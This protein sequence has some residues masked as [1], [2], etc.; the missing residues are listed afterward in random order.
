MLRIF[1]TVNHSGCA[2][3]RA[4]LPAAKIAKLGLA[5]T[6]CFSNMDTG[7]E[8]LEAMFNW[9]NV[10]VGQ[11]AAG[12]LS[13]ALVLKYREMGKITSIDYDDLVYS[14]S[15]F[16]PAYR[17]LGTKEVKIKEL[18]GSESYMWKDGRDGFSLKDNLFRCYSQQDIL[19]ISDFITVTNETLKKVYADYI[20][21]QKEKIFIL[22]N[23]IDFDLF[24]PFPKK[25]HKEIRIGWTASSSHHT[26]S[27]L[28]YRIFKKLFERYPSGVKFVILG[29]VFNL[30]ELLGRT[31]VEYSP[32]IGL[33]AYP[34]KFASMQF[35]IGICPL[36]NDEFN[37][38]KSQLKWSEFSALKIPSVV[39]NL[40]PY[41]VVEEGVTGYKAKTEDEF[42]EK[43]SLLIESEKLRQ[44]IGNN[45]F[46][47]NYQDFNLEKN[48]HL[49]VDVYSG[50][51]KLCV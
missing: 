30:D 8:D 40:A 28:V 17:T 10:V 25:P 37:V 32:F 45:A 42:V 48:A 20:P 9:A 21:E 33:E 50:K 49:W 2:W 24:K 15:P 11:S 51:G 43:L 34:I 23:S 7:A 35:D 6:M 13:V 46:E 29:D 44:D 31:H 41:E 27:N 3:W 26:E 47:K 22:P 39:T 4:R 14:C 36:E 18:D 19:K 38:N 16:N 1:F 12:T 5:E